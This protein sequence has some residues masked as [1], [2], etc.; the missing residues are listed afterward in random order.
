MKLM[1]LLFQDN[2][3]KAFTLIEV[4]IAVAILS[5]VGTMVAHW[6]TLNNQYQKRV[7]ELSEKDNIIRSILWDM[8]KDL[9]IARTVLYPRRTTI[10]SDTLKNMVSD[11]KLVFRNFDGDIITYYFNEKKKE[12]VR[13]VIYLPTPNAPANESKVLGKDIDCVIFTNRNELNNLVG[14]YIE[15]GP[16]VQIDSVYLMNE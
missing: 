13:E 9:K 14:I 12:I 4:T 15:S 8:H 6:F 1:H 2:K 5:V 10:T 3:R 11:N 7:T 16:A